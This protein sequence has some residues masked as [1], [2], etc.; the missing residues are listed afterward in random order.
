[1]VFI[2]AVMNIEIHGIFVIQ[3]TPTYRQVIVAREMVANLQFS[4]LIWFA[5]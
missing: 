1:M 2:V 5:V 4:S 3:I